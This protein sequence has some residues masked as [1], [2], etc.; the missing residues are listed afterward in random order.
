[1]AIPRAR[2]GTSPSTRWSPMWISPEVGRSSPAIMRSSVV[3]PE[4]EE[5]SRTRNSPSR[6][7][8][9]TPSTAWRSPKCFLRLRI[10][11]PATVAAL[12]PGLPPVGSRIRRF[13]QVDRRRVDEVVRARRHHHRLYDFRRRAGRRRRP[14]AGATAAG[15]GRKDNAAEK[16]N[17]HAQ[18][19]VHR[20]PLLA[21]G[22]GP[23]IR[24]CV[25]RRGSASQP[26]PERVRVVRQA[27]LLEDRQRHGPH[28]ALAA[29]GGQALLVQPRFECVGL[30][31]GGDRALEQVPLDRQADCV[32]G[33]VP[34]APPPSPL[35][36]VQRREQLTADLA[37][38][39]VHAAPPSSMCA[40][41]A[42][43]GR[44]GLWYPR[45][46]AATSSGTVV[47]SSSRIA[48]GASVRTVVNPSTYPLH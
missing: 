14:P 26:V 3:F 25:V 43:P 48:H 1:M 35:R 5:P 44:S 32:G 16:C 28:P 12:T 36:S 47:K 11:M 20:F 2:G 29:A 37:R 39:R 10:S 27:P 41:S 34:L 9:S 13:R 38:A 19:D 15:Q 45:S 40:S 8:R 18:S 6:I 42:Y 22:G 33:R 17:P 31:V 21:T 23:F 24:K 4:P 30:G 7:D 46:S